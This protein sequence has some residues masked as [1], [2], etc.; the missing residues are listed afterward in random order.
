MK[1]SE[2]R[3][4]SVGDLRVKLQEMAEELVTLRLHARTSG[5]E[6]PHRVRGLKRDIAR[7]HTLIQESNREYR[8]TPSASS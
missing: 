4:L 8:G 3:T 2:L 1:P 7:I 6:K 5:V